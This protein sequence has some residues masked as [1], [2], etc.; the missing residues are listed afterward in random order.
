MSALRD[1]ILFLRRFFQILLYMGGSVFAFKAKG[2]AR[3]R[4][5]FEK[6]SGAFI[7]LGQILALRQDFL[8]MG[9]TAELLSLLNRVPEV[10]LAEIEKVFAEDMGLPISKFFNS[11]DSVPI[12]SGSIAQV[13]R[14][15]LKNNSE[16]VAVKIQR[17]NIHD[18]FESDFILIS[19]LANI[20]DFF[21]ISRT[22]SA[23][24][25]VSD[26]ISWTR[27][28]LDFRHE[29]KNAV[30]I[31]EHSREFKET[32]IPKQYPDLSTKRVLIQEYIEDAIPMEHILSFKISKEELRRRKI[33][34]YTLSLY[35]IEDEMRQ[36]FIQGF[37]HADPHPANLLVMN[38][39]RLVFLDFG[40]V[41]EAR[42]TDQRLLFLKALYGV[43]QMNVN[44]FGINF[45]EFGKVML[46]N[47][48][49]AYFNIDFRRKRAAE[50]MFQ[51]IE[52][53]ILKDFER[54]LHL[55]VDPWFK[56]VSDPNAS[57]YKKSSA[58]IFLR[59]IKKEE[60]FGVRLPRE[61][62]LFF[63]T[64]SILDMVSLQ[65]SPRFDMIKALQ[66]FFEKYPIGSV[67]E[68]MVREEE[69]KKNMPN[70]KTLTRADRGVF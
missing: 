30:A 41:G 50:E 6:S 4:I 49:Q 24:E 38:D 68:L 51:K 56:A 14:A 60:K 19:F 43:S 40:I 62:V 9:Y 52:E 23:Y 17:P 45:L 36:Y 58:M 61:M 15:V 32:V 21:R 59:V 2:P 63:R 22:V 54:E 37:F 5:F 26:F 42:D 7:K 35:L 18:V 69:E 48:L 64:L 11:F 53:L 65:M 25:V 1:T 46:T 8:P 44:V 13:Y 34:P 39:N 57:L 10:P 3:L 29:A 16:V 27:K 70:K 47:E 33:D 12:A 66:A 20:I 31:Y 28:E 67:Y 55:I